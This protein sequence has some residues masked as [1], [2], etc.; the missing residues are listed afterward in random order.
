M[1][2][3]IPLSN[4]GIKA[5]TII[6]EGW[7]LVQWRQC[8][9]VNA[10]V[11]NTIMLGV[12][13]PAGHPMILVQ[14]WQQHQRIDGNNA[15][16]TTKKV[17][18]SGRQWHPCNNGDVMRLRSPLLHRGGSQNGA[19]FCWDG[20]QGGGWTKMPPLV[21]DGGRPTM[22]R[23]RSSRAAAATSKSIQVMCACVSFAVICGWCLVSSRQVIVALLIRYLDV[24]FCLLLQKVAHRVAWNPSTNEI[25]V[26]WTK[27]FICLQKH[28][29]HCMLIEVKGIG[30]L[31]SLSLKVKLLAPPLSL[32]QAWLSKWVALCN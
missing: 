16:T 10:C 15:C 28:K 29:F 24:C 21:G 12:L 22:A 25:K 8:L 11:A 30:G 5:C 27:I 20:W 4:N 14:Q 19:A 17:P 1:I 7:Q 31:P 18:M 9:G 32:S 23:V 2:E 3:T 6:P 13:M 26:V